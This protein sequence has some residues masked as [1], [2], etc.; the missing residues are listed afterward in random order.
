MRNILHDIRRYTYCVSFFLCG[1]VVLSA[2]NDYISNSRIIN[3]DRIDDLNGDCGLLLISKHKDLVINPVAIQ[4]KDVQIKVDG[5][6]EDGLYEYRVIIDKDASRNPKL[7]VS[8]EGNV[9]KTE[10][11]SVIKPDFLIAYLIEEVTN[12]IRMDD[13]TQ[14]NDF[15]TD[16]K[17]AEL[18]FTTSIKGLQ[19]V[20]PIE[21]Q[22]KTEQKVNPSDASIHITSVLIPI[23][24]LDEAREKMEQAKKA[25]DD[26][27]ALL[28]KDEKAAAQ[29]ANWDKLETLEQARDAAEMAYSELTHLEV[30]ADLTNRLSIDISDLK[31]KMKRCYAVL[32]LTKTDTVHVTPYDASMAEGNRLF[33][34]RK[35]KEAKEVFLSAK[36]DKDADAGQR[37]AAE[38][39]IHLCDTCIHYDQLAGFALQEVIRLRKEGG[40]QQE[41]YTYISGAIGFMQQLYYINPSVFYSERI[42]RLEKQLEKQPLYI[43]FT[44]VEWKTLQEGNALQG[45]EVWAYKGKQK[46][47]PT[48]YNSDRKF[49]KIIDR[50]VTDFELVGITNEKGVVELEFNRAQL[51]TGLFF[52]PQNDG[53][54]KIEYRNMQDVMLQGEGDFMH[55]QVR[56]KMYTK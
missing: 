24:A 33:G 31:G 53:K 38:T 16:D 2:Q 25:H 32:E 42:E 8:R 14:P 18:E 44:C 37:N 7:E 26:W 9:Y 34:L 54:T 48:T 22:A 49:R 35:Y 1:T 51:P 4:K 27:F 30:Y 29:D 21:L 3:E 36:N 5:K 13:Q 46:P 15:V 23:A 20:C 50:Q 10:F 55:R 17:L 41:A 47:L 45:L 39:S 6:R 28:G 11:T 12:P 43:M 40:T 19:V 56:M 52:R